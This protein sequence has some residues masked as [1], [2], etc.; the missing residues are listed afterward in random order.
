VFFRLRLAKQLQSE[1]VTLTAAH[2]DSYLNSGQL[3]LIAKFKIVPNWAT[4]TPLT[5]V[6][7]GSLASEAADLAACIASIVGQQLVANLKSPCHSFATFVIYCATK[8]D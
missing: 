4:V 7:L 5:K 1:T 2:L 3:A 8:Q 6:A